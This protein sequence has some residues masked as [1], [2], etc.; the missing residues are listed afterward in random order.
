MA[1]RS[2]ACLLADRLVADGDPGSVVCVGWGVGGGG[3]VGGARVGPRCAALR[4]SML[5]AARGCAACTLKKPRRIASLCCLSF[6]ELASHVRAGADA[7]TAVGGGS[8]G[9]NG[10]R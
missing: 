6:R 10:S 9:S 8:H 5:G 7:G 2:A 1:Q 3:G 4:E